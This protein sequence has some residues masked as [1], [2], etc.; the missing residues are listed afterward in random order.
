MVLTNTPCRLQAG[1]SFWDRAEGAAS[2][3]DMLSSRWGRKS[4]RTPG[5]ALNT[6]AQMWHV[7]LCSSYWPKPVT[8]LI[9]VGW[10]RR[11]LLVEVSTTASPLMGVMCL[12]VYTGKNFVPSDSSFMS[13]STSILHTLPKF[14][15]SIRVFEI[16]TSK[17]PSP[18]FLRQITRNNILAAYDSVNNSLL[19]AS[20]TVNLFSLLNLVL[21][22]RDRLNMATPS[23]HLLLRSGIGVPFVAQWLTNPLV[24]M[25]MQVRSPA[26]LSGLRIQHCRELWCRS[27]TPLGCCA[28]G[29]GR[30]L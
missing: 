6:H 8:S 28:C 26:S 30:Q 9:S 5:V 29:V 15:M 17:I 19:S 16:T 4:N 10:G 27:Q 21:L 24:S 7:W 1:C 23:L 11:I 20:M 22:S 3:W 25:R 13:S 18:H 12:G 2:V 14:T